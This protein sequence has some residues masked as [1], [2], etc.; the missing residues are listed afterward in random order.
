MT[1]GAAIPLGY[2]D[3]LGDTTNYA[4]IRGLI[5]AILIERYGLQLSAAFVVITSFSGGRDGNIT[6]HFK[7]YVGEQTL[8]NGNSPIETN[9]ETFDL[10]ELISSLDTVSGLYTALLSVDKYSACITV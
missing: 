9:S 8:L 5:G 10:D 3:T 1:L 6:A 4:I 7:I 2:P